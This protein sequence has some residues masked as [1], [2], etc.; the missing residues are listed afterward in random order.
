[1][2]VLVTGAYGGIGRAACFSYANRATTLIITGRS[3]HKLDTLAEELKEQYQIN[4]Q[5]IVADINDSEQINAL[6]QQIA[7]TVKRLDVFLHCAGVLTQ[8]PLMF[9][10]VAEIQNAVATNLTSTILFCQQASKLMMRNKKGVIILLSSIVASQGSSGQSV[11]GASKAGIEGLVKSLAKEL[12]SLGI[13]I[14]ALAPGFI[15][16]ELVAH[17]NAEDKSILAQKTSLGRI[18][19]VDDIT[20]VIEFLSSESSRYITGQVIAVDGGLSL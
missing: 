20:P 15:N 9:S 1:M 7:K 13:R 18:G 19:Q 8:K 10:R 5:A 4:V 12:G 17:F 2:I 6:F 11:Y 14:N 3:Q 16:T